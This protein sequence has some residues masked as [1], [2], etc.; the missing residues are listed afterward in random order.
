MHFGLLWHVYI[1]ATEIK[2]FNIYTVG[3][4]PFC[5][6]TMSPKYTFFFYK[7]NLSARFAGPFAPPPPPT[8]H[9]VLRVQMS[10][11]EI[12]VL[13]FSAAVYQYVVL[14][15]LSCQIMV[16]WK[17]IWQY[18]VSR[19]AQKNLQLPLYIACVWD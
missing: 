15:C 18:P 19:N 16:N 11:T 2:A 14:R 8:Y 4:L 10:K 5:Y 9:I 6:I 17:A 13:F 3:E 7:D 12:F 1:D